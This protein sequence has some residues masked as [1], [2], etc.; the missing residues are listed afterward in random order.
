VRSVSGA[1]KVKGLVLPEAER[2][3]RLLGAF[4]CRQR[5]HEVVGQGFPVLEEPCGNQHPV[6]DGEAIGND[7]PIGVG[8]SSPVLSGTGV[9]LGNEGERFPLPANAVHIAASCSVAV[10]RARPWSSLAD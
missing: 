7:G 5:E 3:G 8:K 1:E 2:G 6:A 9:P 4:L 10:P